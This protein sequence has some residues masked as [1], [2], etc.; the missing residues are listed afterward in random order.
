MCADLPDPV[1]HGVVEALVEAA[2]SRGILQFDR[3]LQL[4]ESVR[5]LAGPFAEQIAILNKLDDAGR[6]QVLLHILG[7]Q[8][9]ISTEANNLL[10]FRQ[11]QP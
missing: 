5:L 8:V 3:K 4:G 9:P 7:R 10:P 6:V 1:P 2:D 11:N